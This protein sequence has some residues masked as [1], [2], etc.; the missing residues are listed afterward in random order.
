MK[1]NQLSALRLLV[2]AALIC[3]LTSAAR[4]GLVYVVNDNSTQNQVYGFEVNETTGT[5][6][7]L[8]GF[9]VNAGTGVAQT[10]SEMMTIDAANNRLYVVNDGSDTVS[11]FSINP[12]TGALTP[13][14]F[15]PI[16]LGTGGWNTIAVHPSG[17][18]LIVGDGDT[19]P[20]VASFN[21]TATTATAAAGSPFTTG[22]AR[23]F[24]SIVTPDGNFYYVGGNAGT[25]FGAFSIDAASGVLTPLAGQ[26]FNS[27]GNNPTAFAMDSSGRLFMANSLAN[28]MRAFTTAAGIPTP[29]TGNPFTMGLTTGPDGVLHPNQQFYMIADRT[30]NRVGVYQISGSGAAT[31]LAPVS[32]SPFSSNGTLTQVLAFNSSGSLLFAANGDSRN[33]T[34]FS[35]NTTTGALSVASVQP[36][37][38]AGAAGRLNG[39]AYLNAPSVPDTTQFDF[40]GDGRADVGVFRPGDANWY[41][42]RSSAGFFA[43]QFGVSTDKI[44][45][46]DF[47]GDGKTDIAVFRSGN[48]YWLNSSNGSFNAVQFGLAGDVPVPAH[49]TGDGRAELAVFRGGNW[50]TLNLANNQVQAVQFGLSTDKPV[51]GDYDGDGKS[52]FAVYRDGAWYILGSTAG[53]SAVQFGVAFDTPTV[54]DYDGDG[55]ADQ[56]VYRNGVWYVLGSTQGFNAVQFGISSDT[57][58]AADYDG[59][60]KTDVAVYRDGTWYLLRSQQ[61]F[62]AVQLGLTNDKPI[63]ASYTP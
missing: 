56:A 6:T 58:V 62:T 4:A 19:T 31:M 42:Q 20:V 8:P 34:T 51:V 43:T 14:P 49:Y 61:G 17:S 37:N 35:V 30:G 3:G 52:D 38:S 32:G 47:D 9:P 63:P 28:Q 18:P 50:Y 21:I 55:K 60:G 39:M 41:L 53:F 57:P 25:T 29:V 40:D 45:P 59:D 24:S 12:S 5:L 16:S 13:L 27:G 36:A 44:A 33:V 1:I 11:A 26:P 2:C 7:P 22:T 48:W 15:S 46:A 10:R 23:S 54:G